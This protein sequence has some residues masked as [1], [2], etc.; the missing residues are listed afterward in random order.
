MGRRSR[1]VAACAVA[2]VI[3][4]LAAVGSSSARN[5]AAV[6]ARATTSLPASIAAEVAAAKSAVAAWEKRPTTMSVPSLPS[7]PPTG[8]TLDFIACG[9]PGCLNFAPYLKEATAA[10]GWKLKTLDAGLTP[11]TVAAAYDQA[12]RDKP[13]GVIGS[14]GFPT[15]LFSHQLVELHNEGVPVVL[16][17]QLPTNATGVTA[18]VMSDADN[19]QYGREMADL[20]LA[21]A[22]GRDVHLGMIVTPQVP[23]F[24][25]EHAVLDGIV[26]SSHCVDCSVATL[27]F[28]ETAVGTTLPS[29]V[30]SF[31]RAHPTVNYLY[32]DFTD[33]VAGVPAALAQ[34]GLA[35]KVKILTSN[36]TPEQAAY[37]RAGQMWAT[38]GLPWPETLWTDFNIILRATMHLPVGPGVA[39][40][41]PAMILV[42][43]NLPSFNGQPYFPLVTSYQSIFKTAWHVS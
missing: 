8:K 5:T 1:Y 19:T 9:V 3:A 14:G 35:G 18:V 21:N 40:K 39:V 22:D 41:L 15:S 23:V 31:V 24:A 12:V 29:E 2:I 42:K 17:D 11:Q 38:A 30:V 10:V 32:F 25:N 4:S 26:T 34:A 37:I 6:Q 13:A 36:I 27:Q 28:P 20:I 7:K 33:A 43:S 16:H